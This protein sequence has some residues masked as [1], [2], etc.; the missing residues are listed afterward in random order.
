MQRLIKSRIETLCKIEFD[1]QIKT[2][3]REAVP[4]SVRMNKNKT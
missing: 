2:G 1:Q 4:I 3:Y